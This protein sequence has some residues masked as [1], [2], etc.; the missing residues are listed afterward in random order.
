MKEREIQAIKSKEKII[1]IALEEFAN[2]GYKGASTNAICKKGNISKGLLYH[3]FTSKESL[4][5]SVLEDSL[6]KFKGVFVS[7]TENKNK[8]GI[9][10]ISDY[11]DMKFKFFK[12][13]PLI[14]KILT[15]AILN[16]NLEIAKNFLK[17]VEEENRRI[18]YDV[19][20]TIHINPKFDKEKAFE[21]I[22]MIGEK[23][24]EKHM[25]YVEINEEKAIE[26]FRRDHKI[27]LEMIFEGIDR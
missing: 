15:G 6:N 16:N 27:M 9:D 1:A 11:F 26:D 20:E 14:S 25:K 8:K 7:I 12:E 5:E 21:L 4:Y 19:I 13:N 18:I 3:Y 22:M 23:L 10:Y 17:S 2:N 24:E